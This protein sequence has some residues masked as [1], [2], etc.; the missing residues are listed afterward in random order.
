MY[1]RYSIS[2]M[3]DDVKLVGDKATVI[4]RKEIY[5]SVMCKRY[6]TR[7]LCA[8]SKRSCAKRSDH[9]CVS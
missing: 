2:K 9:G 6:L 8:K 5:R 4:I 1:A 7:L 3:L